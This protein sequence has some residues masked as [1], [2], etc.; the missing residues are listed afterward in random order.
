[1]PTYSYACAACAHRYDVVQ[2]IHDDSL[3]VCPECGGE[4]R[5][6]ISAVGVSFKGSGF[7]RT[8]SRSSKSSSLAGSSSTAAT[9]SSSESSSSTAAAQS[10]STA[11]SKPATTS[12]AADPS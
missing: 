8:D 2:S 6:V 9:S 5:R 1:M 7:Y 3:T 4:L 12:A 11:Q 10:N